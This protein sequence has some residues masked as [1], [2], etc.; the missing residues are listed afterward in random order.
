M[1]LPEPNRPHPSGGAPRSDTSLGLELLAE[2]A[3]GNTARVELCRVRE[4]AQH[5]DKL[6]AV[7]RLHQHIA[8]DQQFF[9]MFV[10]EVWMTAALD[11]PNVVRVVGWGTDAE[12]TYLAVELVEGVSLARLEKTVFETR[13]A[14]TERLVVYITSEL[15]AGL[16]AAHKLA[17]P[18]G[19]HL[20]LVHRDL[21]PG[22]VLVG[23][24]GRVMIADFGLAKAKQRVTKTLTGMMKGQP[25]YMAP[26]QASDR[27]IDARADLFSLGVTMY[28]LFT[29]R[30]PWVGVTEIDTFERM[31]KEP[32]TDI[33]TLRPKIDRELALIVNRLIEKDPNRRF[34]TADEV[35]ARLL[36]WLDT[37]GYKDDNADAVARFVRRNAMRQMR[38]FE[39]AVQGEFVAEAT[40]AKARLTGRT[41][42]GTSVRPAPASTRGPE[43]PAPPPVP[44]SIPLRRRATRRGHEE[45]VNVK[46]PRRDRLDDEHDSIPPGISTTA[47]S[48]V[49][50]AD[51]GEEIPTVVQ[52]ASAA[53]RAAEQK[54]RAA[55]DAGPGPSSGSAPTPI[56]AGR[57]QIGPAAPHQALPSFVEDEDSNEKATEVTIHPQHEAIRAAQARA[58]QAPQPA[59][60]ANAFEVFEAEELPTSPG[61]LARLTPPKAPSVAPPPVAQP[62]PQPHVAPAVHTVPMQALPGSLAPAPALPKMA[63]PVVKRREPVPAPRAP[64]PV[65]PRVPLEDRPTEPRR[66]GPT[67]TRISS[68]RDLAAE[69]DRLAIRAAELFAEAELA[70]KLAAHRSV[71]AQLARE[72]A[73]VAADALHAA[74]TSG[75]EH[76]VSMMREAYRLE[77]SIARGEAQTGAI[78]SSTA[79]PADL[80][81]GDEGRTSAVPPEPQPQREPH[82]ESFA[83]PPPRDS[84][85]PAP[86]PEPPFEAPQR[87][88]FVPPIPSVPPPAPA[89]LAPQPTAAPAAAAAPDPRRE[90]TKPSTRYPNLPAGDALGPSSAQGGDFASMLRGQVFGVPVPFALAVAF[91]IAIAMIVF[92]WFLT[93]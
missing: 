70:A 88:S 3:T 93:S 21:T 78:R 16:S 84:F 67:P 61:R 24:D 34:Q 7:K 87:P 80:K 10:D 73:Q 36:H 66:G 92:V 69:A 30:R 45:P 53:R 17:S 86:A 91:V 6:V 23:F 52:P 11:H 79:P 55:K 20:A 32:A 39:R 8:E 12:G 38:W 81:R 51:W 57:A 60:P 22:N 85:L 65:D 35:R 41:R 2:I 76:A 44:S 13:E 9:R 49:E 15:A 48:E 28:E 82:R 46:L 63:P 25:Q 59:S 77:E 75:L 43:L 50:N 58:L 27:P 71:L 37:H 62:A 42:S 4:P 83:P 33:T 5:R 19:E 89:L 56:V 68:E 26:E 40:R 54:A 14:F 29:G 47:S 72:A 18:E 64:G 31:M 90:P 74:P 1:E